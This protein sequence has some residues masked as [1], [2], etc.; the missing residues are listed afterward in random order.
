[1]NK[2]GF[3]RV[4]AAVPTVAVAD[5]RT[6]CHHICSL[7]ESAVDK[8]VSLL[9]FPDLCITGSTCGDLFYQRLILEEARQ[10]VEDIADFCKGLPI[11]VVVGAPISDGGR[12]VNCSIVI[13][14]G[15]ILDSVPKG[16][17]GLFE[18]DGA[19]FSFDCHPDS[20]IVVL[21]S[22][23][24]QDM[25]SGLRL[26]KNLIAASSLDACAY[27]YCNAGFGESTTDSVY[28]GY[29]AITENGIMLAEGSWNSMEPQLVIADVDIQEI[30]HERAGDGNFEDAAQQ[31]GVLSILNPDTDFGKKLMRPTL[32]YNFDYSDEAL[33]SAAAIQATG[34]ATRLSKINC[35][36][37]IIGIS[38]GLDSTLALLCTVRAFDRLG[39]DRK[40]ITGITMPGFGT[41]E[42]THSNASALM[43]ELGIS[44]REID[45][46]AACRQHLHD[47]GHDGVTQDTAYE[48]AQARERTQIL[49]DVANAENAIVV[50]TGD[51]SELALG[52]C[53][54]NGDHM[55]NYSVNA[56]I[57][58]T[59]VRAMTSRAAA[60]DFSDGKTAG[61]LRDIIATPVS[62]ELKGSGRA[63][64]QKTEDLIG[65]Y[66]LHDFFIW[67]MIG[68]AF[69]PE[70]TIFLAC[71]A[72]KGRFT[73]TEIKKWMA[74]FT[75]R[76]FSQQFKRSCAP[77]GP[78]VTP[79]SLSPRNGWN[80]PSDVSASLY[81]DNIK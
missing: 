55:S 40:G 32:C 62:P 24:I 7:I 37:A 19:R 74:V 12:P 46:T 73:K 54:Y 27:I 67:N 72:F 28:S 51:L 41:S 2:F 15:Q 33:D 11:T 45:I 53:T 60:T 36:K 30:E 17:N 75:G 38:G 76:F 81:R 3:I 9:V 4:A 29:S 63:I 42:R 77:D 52:W 25:S 59:L 49:M 8:Q 78:K 66:E 22:A 6:N 20:H 13:N 44:S 23:D 18:I 16:G 80:M 21:P 10:A 61:I 47:I 48:N 39:L 64:E 58:K 68:S 69:T 50:G 14:D 26:R 56:S 31:G 65:P 71:N 79:V 43:A 5:T 1:M 35:K 57:P 34:L 70:K